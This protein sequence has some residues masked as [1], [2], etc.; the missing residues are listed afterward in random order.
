MTVSDNTIV[1]EGRGHFFK[2]LGEKGLDISKRIAKFFL[3]NIGRVLEIGAKNGTA[4]AS[5]SPKAALS[6]LPDVMNF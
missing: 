3:K 1:A 6:S 5:G 4:F 2:Y